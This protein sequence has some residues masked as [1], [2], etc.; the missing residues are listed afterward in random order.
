MKKKACLAKWLDKFTAGLGRKLDPIEHA[1]FEGAFELGWDAAETEMLKVCEGV[2]LDEFGRTD[3][4]L[5]L[6]VNEQ[7][8]AS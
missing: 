4:Q 1:I 2:E 6:E 7:L 8:E 5:E 3:D